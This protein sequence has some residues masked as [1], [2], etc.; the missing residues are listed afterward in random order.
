MLIERADIQV[1]EGAEQDFATAMTSKGVPLLL[2][3]PGVRSVQFG[4]GVENPQ[5]FMLLVAW[6]TMDSHIAFT[7]SP[8]MLEFRSLLKPFSTGGAMEHFNLY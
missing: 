2:S 6:D 5:K 8:A 7:K 3:A 1:R 4:R